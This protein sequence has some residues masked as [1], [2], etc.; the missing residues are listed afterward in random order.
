MMSTLTRSTASS[1]MYKA[2]TP[3]SRVSARRRVAV[4][5]ADGTSRDG[6]FVSQLRRRTMDLHTKSQAPK[7]GKVDNPESFELFNP[8]REGFMRFMVES[9]IVYQAF[10]DVVHHAPCHAFYARLA[11]T[12]LERSMALTQDI[13]H[14]RR[15]WGVDVPRPSPDLGLAYAELIMDVAANNPPAFVCHY[16]NHYFAHAAGGRIVGKKVRESL[17]DGWTGEF[18][19]WDGDVCDLVG[20]VRDII[21]DVA[22]GWAPAEKQACLMETPVAFRWGTTMLSLITQQN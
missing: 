4:T 20:N 14:M 19:Q 21:E 22:L 10:E 2:P 1:A 11:D 17:L 18:Y 16:Y 15:H 12:G 7:E 5:L 9:R 6:T 13:N 3:A 8:T